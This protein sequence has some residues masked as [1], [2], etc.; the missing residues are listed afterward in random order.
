MAKVIANEHS[1]PANTQIVEIKDGRGVED[2]RQ[3]LAA[4]EYPPLL[5]DPSKKFQKVL[6]L[7][8]CHTF[9]GDA[10]QTLLQFV[11]E[12]PKWLQII[13]CT[14]NPGKMIPTLRSRFVHHEVKPMDDNC[15][16]ALVIRALNYLGSKLDPQ[17]VTSQIIATNTRSA[18]VILGM[19]QSIVNGGTVTN[20][21]GVPQ[22]LFPLVQ[23]A[24][25]GHIHK[26]L[27]ALKEMGREA[28]INFKYVLLTY[29]TSILYTSANAK[30]PLAIVNELTKPISSFSDVEH[31][32]SI[33]AALRRAE[34]AIR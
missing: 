4:N 6:I 3:V 12:P 11:E 8:E 19:V 10:Q 14:T 32:A 20:T 18:R 5:S 9:T 24:A 1:I 2:I 22:E 30:I 23:L 34:Q 17:N 33:V 27:V 21:E 25:Q 13:A 29:C 7:D 28:T 15:I 31:V 16:Y 26:A